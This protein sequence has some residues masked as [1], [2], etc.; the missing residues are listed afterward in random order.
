MRQLKLSI[1]DALLRCASPHTECPDKFLTWSAFSLIGAVLK[2]R[3]FIKDGLITLFPNQYIVLV[4]PPGIGK[5]TAINFSWGLLKAKAVNPLVNIVQDRV[6]APKILER[7]ATGWNS[8]I[9]QIVNNQVVIGGTQDHT[10]T[11]CS[12]EL[13]VLISASDWMLEFLCESWDRNSYDYDTKNKGT[14]IVKSMCTSLIAG[15]VP[16]YLQNLERDIN[17]SIN[18]GFT[19]RCLFIFADAPSKNL[20][21]PPPIDSNPQSLLLKKCIEN[22]LEHISF[23]LSGEYTYNTEARIKFENFLTSIRSN[24]TYDSEPMLNFKS[25]IRS[26]VLKLAMVISAARKDSLIIEGI[27]MDNSIAYVKSVVIDLEKIFSGTGES[28]LA[29]AMAKV[30]GYIEKNGIAS[31]KELMKHLYRHMSF[32]TLERVLYTLEIMEF[33]FPITRGKT[34]YYQHQNG[35]VKP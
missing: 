20:P 12:T 30:Q 21:L 10:C 24:N 25:R 6:T 34:T 32:E 3:V 28:E 22:D 18:G 5:G 7:I 35:R 29:P 4:S 1:Y 33:C 9:P 31:K 14:S 13:R 11:I 19:S 27:D 16:H 17:L 15:T 26:H 8:S 2:N 23:N